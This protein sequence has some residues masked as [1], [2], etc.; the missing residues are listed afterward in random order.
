MEE[1]C[2]LRL[3]VTAGPGSPRRVP[4]TVH[5][6]LRR[7]D[8]ENTPAASRTAAASRAVALAATRRRLR[9]RKTPR[10]IVVVEVRGHPRHLREI[11]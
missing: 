10:M 1:R 2:S 11:F 7:D 8:A 3:Q 5:R 6:T 9:D 4:R